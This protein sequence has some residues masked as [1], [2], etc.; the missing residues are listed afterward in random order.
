M[1]KTVLHRLEQHRNFFATG[2]TKDV[3]FRLS[4]LGKLKKAIVEHEQE[5]NQALTKDLGKSAFEAYAS[6]IGFVL[7]SIS[8]FM[9]HVKDWSKVRKVKTPLVHLGSKSYIYPEPY[10][11]VLIVG[12]FN[13]PFQLVM[14]PMI[15]AMAAGNCVLLK[16][17]EFTP[18]VSKVM[19]KIIQENFEEGYISVM[20]GGKDVTSELIHAPFDYIFFTGSVEVGK[21]VMKAAAENLVPVTLELGGK[22]PCIVDKDANLEVAA[23]RIVWG[24]YMNAGQTCVAPDYILVHRDVKE[25]LVK[26]LVRTIKDFYGENPQESRDYGRIVNERQFDRLVSLLDERKVVAGGSH[27]REELF[28]EPTLMNEVSWDDKVMQEEIFGPILPILEY[29]DLQQAIEQINAKPKPLALYLF[30]ENSEVEDRVI[31]SCSYGGGCIN[32]TVTHLTNPNLPFGGVGP[33]GIGSYH[34]K[35]SFETFSHKKSVMKKSTKV[36]LSFIYP[37]YSEKS[38]NFLRKIMK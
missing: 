31:Q 25:Q 18:N 12:P 7:D 27:Q 11:T 13:Y 19:A 21:I 35:D 34:G 17:S 29:G 38:I 22:S 37:P 28:M 8:L 32:D 6:E 14:E 10:G 33:S 9:K 2:R 20:E 16:P 1:M 24:K 3:D 15:G 26:N 23:K 4:Q 36:N 5:L 30:T